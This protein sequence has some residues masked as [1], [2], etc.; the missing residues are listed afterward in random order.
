MFAFIFAFLFVTF[1]K[2][3][4]FY[5]DESRRRYDMRR[6]T[7]ARTGVNDGPSIDMTSFNADDYCTINDCIE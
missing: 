3:T 1:G 2:D 5:L 7:A 6:P 4:V